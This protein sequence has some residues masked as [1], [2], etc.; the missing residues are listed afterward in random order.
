MHEIR[1]NLDEELYYKVK[2]EAAEKNMNLSE[3][4][5]DLLMKQSGVELTIDFADVYKYIDKMEYLRRSID[6]ILPTIY[7]S[8]KI[9]EQEA[10][11]IK[12]TL[13]HI[14]ELGDDVW[15]YVVA[16]RSEMFDSVH[17]YLY[18]TI[19]KYSYTKRQNK[20]TMDEL[21]EKHKD[22]IL[23]QKNSL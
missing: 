18:K 16:M 17:K 12:K 5:R 20:K 9:Y 1:I 4:F 6:S 7:R 13:N 19:R 11:L 15:R 8:G 23:T 22:L 21:E 3:Y 2:E 14:T 10:I